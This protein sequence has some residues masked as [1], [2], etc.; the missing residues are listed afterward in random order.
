[1]L[2]IELRLFG[3]LRKYSDG[4]T[5]ALEIEGPIRLS[6]FKEF[7]EKNLGDPLVMDC[8][9]AQDTTILAEDHELTQSGTLAVLPPVCGG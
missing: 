9:F 4:K 2:K 5:L 1:M 6:E 7:L 3:A 8:A